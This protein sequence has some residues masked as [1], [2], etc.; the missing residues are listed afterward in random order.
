M[1]WLGDRSGPDEDAAARAAYAEL[2]TAELVSRGHLT[3]RRPQTARRPADE[4][5]EAQFA[6]RNLGRSGGGTAGRGPARESEQSPVVT[7]RAEPQVPQ[8]RPG[9]DMGH[10][11]RL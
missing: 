10:V 6:R 4:P 5:V 11:H 1:R 8:P 9:E 2:L 7:R 3:Q